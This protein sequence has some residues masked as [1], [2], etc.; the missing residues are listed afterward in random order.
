MRYL[1]FSSLLIAST[2]FLTAA[3]QTKTQR[4]L[5]FQINNPNNL[6][7]VSLD[8]YVYAMELINNKIT[9]K[10]KFPTY[11]GLSGAHKRVQGD[12]K[13]PIGKY[14]IEQ[15]RP[16]GKDYRNWQKFGGYNLH[17]NY[18][19][20]FDDNKNYKGGAIGI[21]G[22]RVHH[23]LGCARVLDGTLN[24]PKLGHKNIKTIRNFIKA[25][26]PVIFLENIPEELLGKVGTK[27]DYP[28]AKFWRLVLR[29]ALTNTQLQHKVYQYKRSNYDFRITTSSEL[30]EGDNIFDAWNLIDEDQTTTWIPK[31]SD[32]K[33]KQAWVKYHFP[34]PR[35]L[36]SINIITGYQKG[37]RWK[38][39]ARASKLKL[40][41]D[42][43]KEKIITLKDTRTIQKIQLPK[44]S[45]SSI[46]IEVID[47]VKGDK[48]QED[49][50]I[51]SLLFE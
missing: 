51:S 24:H 42:N 27:L 35:T 47:Y 25:K 30:K 20:R 46:K 18:P 23:T 50:C 48:Y 40:I 49:V 38:Q 41:F 13:T 37:N 43:K 10:H 31:R 14:H 29:S 7:D 34:K 15:I 11:Y 19:N 6:S 33:Q 5:V 1:L 26:T 32:V 21:H 17:L 3:T 45:T 36:K 39:N 16:K 2:I 44:T 28:S 8:G 9:I 22:G 4:F 12:K